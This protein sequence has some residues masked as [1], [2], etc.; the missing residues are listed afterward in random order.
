[1]D[2]TELS[3]RGTVFSFCVVHQAAIA[4][5]DPPYVVAEVEL[6][7]QSGL[8][9]MSNIVD[10]DREDVYIGLLVEASF[11]HPAEDEALLQ[12]RPRPT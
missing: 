1:M 3:G 5:F 10:C 6:E 2:W 8:R 12:F 9:L 7:E 4:G 11:E